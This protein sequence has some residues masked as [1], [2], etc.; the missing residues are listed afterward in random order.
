MDHSNGL[1]GVAGY[2]TSMGVSSTA[3]QSRCKTHSSHVNQGLYDIALPDEYLEHYY[4][5]RA[6]SQDPPLHDSLLIYEYEGQGSP[7]G[8]VGS[9]SLLEDNSDLQFLNELGTK[10]KTLASICTPQPQ[11]RM[12]QTDKRLTESSFPEVK[13][14]SITTASNVNITQSSVSPTNNNQSSTSTSNVNISQSSVSTTNIN[15]SSN[16]SSNVN[17]SQPPPTSPPATEV[18]NISNVSQSAPLPRSPTLTILL[19]QQPVYYSTMKP[20]MQPMMQ[21]M[22]VINRPIGPG[23]MGGLLIQGNQVIPETSTSP[24]SSSPTSHTIVGPGSPGWILGSIPSGGL[25]GMSEVGQ[26]P[27][28]NYVHVERQVS[29][30]RR[31][32]VPGAPSLGSLPKGAIL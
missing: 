15:Q 11:P 32:G 7:A 27:D 6:A 5:R 25:G 2:G 20:M 13:R 10:F 23:C 29:V 4:T 24:V 31:A 12:K 30:P 26:S 9:C 28:G 22:V 19:Q 16:S 17:I 1:Q 8:S 14:E 3:I 18:T 21:H